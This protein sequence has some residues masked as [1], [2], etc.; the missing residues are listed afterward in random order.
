MDILAQHPEATREWTQRLKE[1]DLT[2]EVQMHVFVAVELLRAGSPIPPQLLDY[3][4][5]NASELTPLARR[6]LLGIDLN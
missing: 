4:R 2:I 6:K 3:L 1:L 5:G